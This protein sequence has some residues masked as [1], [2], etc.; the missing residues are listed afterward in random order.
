MTTRQHIYGL[1]ILI[2]FGCSN[3]SNT[4]EKKIIEKDTLS[5]KEQILF[6]KTYNRRKIFHI[7]TFVNKADSLLKRLK[8]S[9]Y[10]FES[11]TDTIDLKYKNK[12][13]QRFKV[14]MFYHL[15]SD[16]L[17]S[18]VRHYIFAPKTK[19]TLRV[20][21]IEA[22]YTS[23][24]SLESKMSELLVSMN[25]SA[26]DGLD[27]YEFVKVGLTPCHDYIA[28]GN[29]KLY[30]LN[31]Y[32]PYSRT[33]FDQF[34]SCFKSVIDTTEYKDRIICYFGGDCNEKNVP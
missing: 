11:K 14:G 33:E 22:T 34:I 8:G 28:T 17:T 12:E 15:L 18:V 24:E 23:K 9:Q 30:W 19:K 20:Y 7:E 13:S 29:N 6:S 10:N 25:D 27:S 2:I 3:S 5:N 26:V 32:Y 21:L 16:S 31:L 4:N 1:L